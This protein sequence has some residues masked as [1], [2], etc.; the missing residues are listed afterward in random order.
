MSPTRVIH[1]RTLADPPHPILSARACPIVMR[2][3]RARAGLELLVFR[4]PL[5]GTQLVKGTI[6]FGETPMHAALRELHEESGI[7]VV[8]EASLLGTFDVGPPWQV[9][10]AFLVETPALPDSWSHRAPDD[11]GHVFRFF[12]HPLADDAEKNWHPV[13]AQA[14]PELQRLLLDDGQDAAFPGSS[15]EKA[16]PVSA[17]G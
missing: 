13:S 16:E 15:R 2:R 11:G 7:P 8:P 12:W 5:A 17:R 9:W 10:H 3:D 4:H 14:L 1:S 6:E